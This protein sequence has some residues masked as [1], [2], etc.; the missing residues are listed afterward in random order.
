M[1]AL[2]LKHS[3]I[4]FFFYSG[5][6]RVI[7]PINAQLLLIFKKVIY[8]CL[9]FT[10]VKFSVSSK[11]SYTILWL[12]FINNLETKITPRLVLTT[13]EWHFWQLLA[14][15]TSVKCFFLPLPLSV[16]GPLPLEPWAHCPY[17]PGYQMS[18]SPGNALAYRELLLKHY[19]L[20]LW[21]SATPGNHGWCLNVRFPRAGRFQGSRMVGELRWWTAFYIHSW[22]QGTVPSHMHRIQC[23]R[24]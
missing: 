3:S 8:V 23:H 20:L 21:S 17:L 18:I 19:F 10:F 24:A 5:A 16:V 15:C 7:L 2:Q 4:L 13:A 6:P 14:Y 22:W 9:I 1:S 12:V 11:S